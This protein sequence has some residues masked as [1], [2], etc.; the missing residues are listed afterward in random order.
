MRQSIT[1]IVP[2]LTIL[3]AA[4][5]VVLI[6]FKVIGYGFLPPDDAMRHAAKVI[7]GKDWNRILVMR[8]GVTMDSH[9]GWH[10][11]LGA[12]RRVAGWD[13]HSL[14][15][16]S[17]ISLFIL[18]AAWP[19]FFV[20][21]PESWLASLLILGMAAPGFIWRL[22]LGRPYIFTM[23]VTAVLCLSW[24]KF[25]DRKFPFAACAA[26]TLLIAASTYIH[27]S[28]YM[29]ALPL[30]ALLL[31][32]EW[33][34]SAAFGICAGLGVMIGAS[35][36]GQPLIFLKQTLAHLF[37]AFG[38]NEAEYMLVSEF[39]PGFGDATIAIAVAFAL[40]WCALRG[41]WHKALVDNPV[42]ILGLLGFVLS[43]FTRRAWLDWGFPATAAWMALVI[44]DFFASKPEAGSPRRFILVT[45]L[46][47]VL[48]VSVTADVGG[49]WTA[50]KPVDQI[51]ADN[52]KQAEWLPEPGGIIY[53]NDMGIFYHIF[54][55]NPHADWRY[56]LGFEPTL[57]PKEDLEIF[58]DIQRSP[59]T[60]KP[61]YGWINKMR[62]Q[63][64]LIL[65]SSPASPPRI[66]DLEW[67]Y[68]ALNTWIGRLPR[69]PAKSAK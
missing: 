18:F 67:N 8:E 10:A 9:P 45:A 7:S 22:V 40:V 30:A 47:F 54:F 59:W 24:Q 69:T 51:S 31:A 38:K 48:F 52:P 33:R 4:F 43:L 23:A 35:L 57:M 62:P 37:L 36:T 41:R 55:W 39:R 28:W 60:F 11:I 6:P 61:F 16:F 34:A 2:L 12:V 14:V 53:S 29:F 32:R 58:R 66:P 46:G 3:I 65:R 49:R 1:N 21:Y 15:L 19:L 50:L 63:D 68:A 26:L 56:M 44:D 64:R 42:F 20:R 27:C 25:K 17:V 5:L 13:A